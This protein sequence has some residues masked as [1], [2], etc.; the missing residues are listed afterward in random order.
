MSSPADEL[1]INEV[2]LEDV[3]VENVQVQGV[4][5]DAVQFAVSSNLGL[6]L[7]EV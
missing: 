1:A 3:H 2:P 4:R 6:S 7:I 5:L